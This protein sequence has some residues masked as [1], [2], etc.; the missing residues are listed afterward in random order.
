MTSPIGQLPSAHSPFVDKDGRPT[1]GAF[2]FYTRIAN[3]FL[4]NQTLIGDNASNIAG[5]ENALGNAIP[6][7]WGFIFGDITQQADLVAKF[8]P[9][10]SPAFTTAVGFNGSP[11]IAKQNVTGAWAGNTAGKNLCIALDAIG[12][13]TDSTTP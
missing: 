1:R 5:L 3:L 7:Y 4:I 6:A 11:A 12:L 8:A 10:D 13:I 2:L 9:I